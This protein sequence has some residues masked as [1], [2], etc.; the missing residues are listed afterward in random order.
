MQVNTN[1]S[2][3]RIDHRDVIVNAFLGNELEG[4][5]PTVPAPARRAPRVDAAAGSAQPGRGAARR[6]LDA[7][8][9][10]L[11]ARDAVTPVTSD[12]TRDVTAET[13]AN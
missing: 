7:L 2:I 5:R 10:R 9:A 13:R 8:L 12:V 6:G 1:G 3:R 11:K 4:A